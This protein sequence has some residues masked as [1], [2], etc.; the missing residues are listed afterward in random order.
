MASLVPVDSPSVWTPTDFPDESAWSFELTADDRCLDEVR[1]RR[2]PYRPKPQG[3]C[4]GI[5]LGRIAQ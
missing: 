3:W 1:S 2:C 5:A 4:E